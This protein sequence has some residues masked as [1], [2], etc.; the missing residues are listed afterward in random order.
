MSKIKE[1]LYCVRREHGRV[2][3]IDRIESVL[4]QIEFLNPGETII[5]EKITESEYL[6]R[7]SAEQAFIDPGFA[8]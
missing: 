6:N 7:I 4:A 8:F 5:I 3:F 1:I 2:L